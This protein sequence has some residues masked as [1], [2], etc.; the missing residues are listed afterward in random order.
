MNSAEIAQALADAKGLPR[1]LATMPDGTV[2]I[3]GIGRLGEAAGYAQI[4]RF[5]PRNPDWT[6]DD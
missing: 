3:L 2:R 6:K 5:N 4:L 1:W